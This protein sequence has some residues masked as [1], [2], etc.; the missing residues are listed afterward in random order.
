MKFHSTLDIISHLKVCKRGATLFF[1]NSWWLMWD[2]L[3]SSVSMK[4]A[5][6][7]VTR[8]SMGELE[9]P[10]Q[11]IR[12]G[13]EEWCWVNAW[14]NRLLAARQFGA[15]SFWSVVMFTI[16]LHS[17]FLYFSSVPV[18]SIPWQ[19]THCLLNGSPKVTRLSVN[20]TWAV[21]LK[22]LLRSSI[23]SRAR[24]HDFSNPASLRKTRSRVQLGRLAPEP[25]RNHIHHRCQILAREAIF[26]A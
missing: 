5:S 10:Q 7:W 1:F 20:W 19:V 23:L 15:S 11:H 6:L 21:D 2:R 26:T 13:V 9:P 8:S 25:Q 12:R 16:L 17:A 18:K 4:A 24:M 14:R 3:A 22:S